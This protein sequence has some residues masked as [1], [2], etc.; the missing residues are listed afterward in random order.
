V[1]CGDRVGQCVYPVLSGSLKI[2]LGQEYFIVGAMAQFIQLVR[3]GE[4]PAFG[5]YAKRA[6]R[7][8]V[9]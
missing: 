6:Y 8:G 1:V 9:L 7:A 5:R 2:F 4:L 3:L